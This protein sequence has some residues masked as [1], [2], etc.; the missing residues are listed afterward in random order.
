MDW[1]ELRHYW[2][3][4]SSSGNTT[5]VYSNDVSFLKE[6]AD[7]YHAHDFTWAW[8]EEKQL[9]QSSLLP[10]YLGSE[11]YDQYAIVKCREG[12][13]VYVEPDEDSFINSGWYYQKG[14]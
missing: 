8:I 1:Y 11:Y 7:R 13:I 6:K 10:R 5:R 2:R 12:S 9:Y 14:S 3:E 4:S